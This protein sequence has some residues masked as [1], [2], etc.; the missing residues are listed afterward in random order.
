MADAKNNGYFWNSDNADRV[1]DADSF[2]NWLKK[3]FTTGVFSG[4]LMVSPAG[5]MSLSVSPG[6]CNIEGKVRIFEGTSNL[7]LDPA[8]ASY[9]RIDSVV[10]TCD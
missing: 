2:S 6:Y 7:T 1:Y 4:D 9:P 10:I 3:F 5:G 8:S